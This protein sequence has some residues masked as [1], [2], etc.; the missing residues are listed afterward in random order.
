MDITI[1]CPGKMEKEFKIIFDEYQKRCKNKIFLREFIIK[2]EDKM[3]RIEMESKYILDYILKLNYKF[4]VL[5]DIQGKLFSSEDLA[6]FFIQQQNNSNKNLIFVI[7]G[8][9]GVNNLVKNTSNLK[10]SFG[11]NTWPHNLMKIML[12]EQIFRSETIIEGRGYHH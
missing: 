2:E 9:F 3:R 8:A 4:V 5:L 10:I 12:I 1:I 7:G 11:K 6:Q